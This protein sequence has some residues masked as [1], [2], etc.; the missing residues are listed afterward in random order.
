MPVREF[1]ICT[2]L[3]LGVMATMINAQ[4][5]ISVGSRLE[6]FVDDF[7]IEK[8][9]GVQLQLQ[10]PVVREE[11][12]RFD[13]PWEGPTSAYVTIFRDGDRF[14]MYYRGTSTDDGQEVTCVAESVDGI[15]WTR[16]RL[17]LHEFGGSKENNIVW[18]G[19]GAHA[20]TPF[21]DPNPNARPDELYK[22]VSPGAGDGRSVL[23]AFVSSDGYRWRK[24]QEE[25]IITKGAFDSQNVAFWDAGRKEYVCYFRDFRNG[26]RD[27]KRSTSKDFR[28]WS[29]PEWLTYNL[30][31]EHYYTNAILPY[32]R[33]PHIYVGFPKRF[34]PERKAIASHDHDG[35]SDGVF[36]SSR[37]GLVFRKW[38]EAFHRPGL[39][40]ENWTDRNNMA[41]WGIFE[42]V[43]GEISIYYS[44]HY[45]HTTNGLVRTTIRSDGFVAVHADARGGEMITKPIIFDGR[46][47]VLNYSTSAVGGVQVEIQNEDGAPVSGRSLEDCPIIYGDEIERVVRWNS[48]SDLST[49][50]GKPVRL[51]FR[52][53]DADLYSIRFR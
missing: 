36:I 23:Y 25:P 29:E 38:I 40:A 22:A 50:A 42:L 7:L 47:L 35:V 30:P 52:L 48:G 46:E 5:A 27:I 24:L 10:H 49:L 17:G 13:A 19:K 37:D 32:P 34:V 11:V 8:M 43:P 45:R 14:R 3:T 51:R 33:A 2:I 20:L 12:F 28:N 9:D 21:K 39:D 4:S 41:A 18:A 16:P 26:K 31:P 6:P 53:S 15:H 1:A 44:R